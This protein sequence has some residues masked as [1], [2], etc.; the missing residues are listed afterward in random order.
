V[1]VKGV[2]K[3]LNYHVL[4][5]HHLLFPLREIASLINNK[6]VL[7]I[8]LLSQTDLQIIA[9]KLS[10][11][12]ANVKG[13]RGMLNYL[14]LYNHH[15]LFPLREIASMTNNKNVLRILLLFETDLHL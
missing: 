13:R 6:N 14:L 1:N 3:M 7:Q 9:P 4:Y 10:G 12:V 5:N 8:S 11:N 2:K 15:L